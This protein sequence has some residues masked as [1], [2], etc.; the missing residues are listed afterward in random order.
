MGVRIALGARVADVARLVIGDGLRV[1]AVGI[2][3]GCLLA[4]LAGHWVAPL[5][6]RIAPTDPAVFVAVIAA[7]LLVGAAACAIPALRATRV[8]PNEALRAD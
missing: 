3:L 5:L 2:A 4:L 7:L 1:V 8:D 6:F